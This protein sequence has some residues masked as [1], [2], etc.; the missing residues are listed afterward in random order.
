M[1]KGKIVQIIGTVIDVAF[2]EGSK[3][4]STYGVL[5]IT[6][7]DGSEVLAE[8]VKHL[9]LTK[10]RAIALQPTDD[11]ERGIEVIDTGKM[12]EVPV[13][14]ET[15]GNIFN[16]IGKSPNLTNL[17]ALILSNFLFFLRA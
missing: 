12:I 8:V 3:L 15:M 1:N 14:P 17:G 7:K 13:G 9:D 5:K 6:K 4:P 16:V 11:L 10:V 2:P